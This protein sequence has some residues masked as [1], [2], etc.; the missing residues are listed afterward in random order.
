MRSE[1][2]N[3]ESIELV[4]LENLEI[5]SPRKTDVKM[6]MMIVM[7]LVMMMIMI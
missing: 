3:Q 4:N 1:S 6:I 7:A 5:D 2:V